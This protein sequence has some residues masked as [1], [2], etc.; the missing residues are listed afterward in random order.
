MVLGLPLCR[1]LN[2]KHIPT[3]R[4]SSI[5]GSECTNCTKKCKSARCK[6]GSSSSGW[7]LVA[8]VNSNVVRMK[9]RQLV[10]GS[11]QAQGDTNTQSG[12]EYSTEGGDRIAREQK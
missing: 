10:Q 5:P 3:Q 9:G 12:S 11:V 2:P 7:L 1:Q 8:I 4:L 6:C